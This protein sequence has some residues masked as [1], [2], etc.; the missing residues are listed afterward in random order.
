MATG[1]KD[2]QTAVRSWLSH[3]KP[4][5][6]EHERYDQNTLYLSIDKHRFKVT[7]PEGYPDNRD[8]YI[9]FEAIGDESSLK[10]A[11]SIQNM[12][13]V[14]SRK[15]P[16]LFKVLKKFSEKYNKEL[17]KLANSVAVSVESQLFI[18]SFD[19]ELE[20]LQARM[21]KNASKM[22]SSLQ[23]PN[24]QTPKLFSKKGVVETA[25]RAFIC[26]KQRFKSSAKISVE[27]VEDNIFH[28]RVYMRD[29]S[30]PD[31]NE[32]IKKLKAEHNFDTI[33]IDVHLHDTFF[34]TYPPV[35]RC[36]K[37]K[38]NIT[39]KLSQINMVKID[40]WSPA[41]RPVDVITKIHNI[42]DEHARIVFGPV[43]KQEFNELE[44]LFMKLSS[45]HDM[46]KDEE[47]LDKDEY[48]ALYRRSTQSTSK[49][50]TNK[51]SNGAPHFA[52]GTG[53][54]SGNCDS[55]WRLDEY[56]KLQAEKAMQTEM[57]LK[58]VNTEIQKFTAE[59]R[60]DEF[61]QIVGD[62]QFIQFLINT[63]N[64]ASVL[65]M[66]KR[67]SMYSVLFSIIQGI[68]T[69]DCIQLFTKSYMN[70]TL[71]EALNEIHNEAKISAMAKGDTKTDNDIAPMII[72]VYELVTDLKGAYEQVVKDN[73]AQKAA[74]A[75]EVEEKLSAE[76]ELYKK[77][78]DGIQEL[79]V[80]VCK[81]AAKSKFRYA[82]DKKDLT[83]AAIS[84]ISS[85]IATVYKSAPVHWSSSILLRYDEDNL[86]AMR[87]MITGP[88][89]TPYW[90]G[91]FIFDMILPSN[92]PNVHPQMVHVNNGGVRF[93]PNLYDSG[94][95]CLSLLGTWHSNDPSESWNATTSTLN[96]LFTSIQSL[97]L[98][99]QPCFNEPGHQRNIGT[100]QGNAE[101]AG[102]NHNKRY[103]TMVHSML[104]TLNQIDDIYPE[105]KEPL[106]FHFRTKKEEIL[107]QID[108]WHN[109]GLAYS[110]TSGDHSRGPIGKDAYTNIYNTLRAKLIAL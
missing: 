25:T 85:E 73:E 18:N 105:F 56:E 62:S 44:I 28:W 53:Y 19:V 21:I 48:V 51:A 34:P 106:L 52:K 24:N 57:I 98:V 39:Y 63:L 41:T 100:D 10:A 46:D 104:G 83:S 38:L 17:E 87:V 43:K 37:P 29:F 4:G 5:F 14:S 12:K 31:L 58:G 99:E 8:G 54:S 26:A 86:A 108:Q 97:I 94:K 78:V 11:I 91:A 55:G 49:K 84:R 16:D 82:K 68:C 70:I 30:N 109:D 72:A 61:I 13:C 59:D 96:Q 9:E 22:H 36:A 77:Y 88:E 66:G 90:N 32:D 95:V 3:G 76:K 89:D 50:G 45:L 7:V 47:N 69:I 80:D 23:L 67:Y 92:Y 79:K 107:K 71:M 110:G 93:N 74:D 103:Y 42:I 60:I 1:A 65:D 102:Y 40:Y 33:V 81:I 20:A 75:K 101:N 35:I 6:H 2:Y 64:S 27:L 15:K